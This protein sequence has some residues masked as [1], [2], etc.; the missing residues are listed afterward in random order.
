MNWKS[1]SYNMQ[2]SGKYAV[3]KHEV[4]TGGHFYLAWH[5]RMALSQHDSADEARAACAAHEAQP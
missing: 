5:D 1:T 3:T 2:T 4:A